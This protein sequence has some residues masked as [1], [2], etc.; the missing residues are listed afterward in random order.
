MPSSYVTHTP[1]LLQLRLG[2]GALWQAPETRLEVMD[3][4]VVGTFHQHFF[5]DATY[6][7]CCIVRAAHKAQQLSTEATPVLTVCASLL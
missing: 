4:V 1:S 6:V 2:V 5:C 7:K 3:A